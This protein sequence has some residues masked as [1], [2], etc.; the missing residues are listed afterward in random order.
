MKELNSIQLPGMKEPLYI[1]KNAV[2]HYESEEDRKNS[3][4]SFDDGDI[5]IITK[6]AF[7]R[8]AIYSNG[9]WE[10]IIPDDI[11][12]ENVKLFENGEIKF[13]EK[14]ELEKLD[15]IAIEKLNLKNITLK[16]LLTI[17]HSRKQRD[18]EVKYPEIKFILPED[19]SFEIGTTA[20]IDWKIEFS[21]G[22]YEFGPQPTG[23]KLTDLSVISNIN[24]SKNMFSKAISTTEEAEGLSG[25]FQYEVTAN[26]EFFLKASADYV[27]MSDEFALDNFGNPSP[28]RISSGTIS[29]T[30][31]SF[32]PYYPIFYGNK[33]SLSK[34]K[35]TGE[36]ISI[37]VDSSYET[38]SI[39]IPED[40]NDTL[41]D[42]EMIS[43]GMKFSVIKL[44]ESFVPEEKY[45]E[46]NYTWY[47]YTPAKFLDG[48]EFRFIFGKDV[49]NE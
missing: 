42:I 32:T 10:G 48:T 21:E 16:E 7:K 1:L 14:F 28:I 38:L 5:S 39:R 18:P 3:S 22:Y 33:D 15:D 25:T 2:Y 34:C 19:T 20:Y 44:F 24:T 8:F 29:E 37:I 4:D 13:Y 36:N 35:F 46:K 47:E 17:F 6:G 40:Y 31:K 41:V 23:V 30:S 43:N 26:S 12:F 27:N 11:L 9:K 45:Y 49:C